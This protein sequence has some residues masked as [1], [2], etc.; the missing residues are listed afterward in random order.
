MQRLSAVTGCA[1][2]AVVSVAAEGQVES[3]FRQ[4]EPAAHPE[5]YGLIGH[6]EGFTVK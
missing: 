4:M 1:A 5:A 6:V 3:S 2:L